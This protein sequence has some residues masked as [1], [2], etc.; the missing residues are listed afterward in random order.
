MGQEP[1]LPESDQ[2]REPPEDPPP[3]QPDPAL[4]ANQDRGGKP[5]EEEVR[6]VAEREGR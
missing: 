3:F 4:F 5:S 1:E 6:R 2:T